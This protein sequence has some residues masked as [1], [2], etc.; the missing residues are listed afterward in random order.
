MGLYDSN[1]YVVVNGVKMLTKDYI[2]MKK[3]V[4]KTNTIKKKKAN[5]MSLMAYDIKSMSKKIKLIK[6]LSVYYSNAYK[7]WGTIARDVIQS[8]GIR[9]TFVFY[10]SK[11]R[12]M[13]DTLNKIDEIG[14]KNEKAI[15][16][17]IEKLSYQ[18]DDIRQ[19][20]DD[21]CTN[22]IESG[23]IDKYH[24]YE[25]INGHGK[26]LGLKTLIGRSWS[27]T[28]ELNEMI[29]H[30]TTISSNG[31]NPFEYTEKTYNGMISCWSKWN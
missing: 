25:F 2:K 7:Q 12:E 5:D 8:D 22:V 16:Q 31:V 26:R 20:I 9:Q 4:K 30:C 1:D 19:Y 23:V 24:D 17:Y 3:G 18:L 11:V 10:R 28:K 15:Y 13:Q 29:N 21:L 27:A 14:K 6:S